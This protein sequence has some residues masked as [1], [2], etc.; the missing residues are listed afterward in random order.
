[1]SSKLHI[2]IHGAGGLG[3]VVGGYLAK[4]GHKVTLISRPAHANAINAGGLKIV[5]RLGDMVIKDNLHAVTMPAQV[6]GEIDYYILLTKAKDAPA[7]L[8][9][10]AVLVGQVKTALTM[11]NGVGKESLLVDCFGKDKVIGGSIIEGGTL[12]EPGKVNNHVTAPTTAFFGELTGGRSD[13]ADR[14]AK[15][16][17]EANLT[18]QSVEDIQHVLWEKVVQV[19]G[20]SAWS[21]STLSAIPELDYADGIS[22]REGA[23]HYVTIAKELIDTYKAMGYAPQDFY[24]P[25]SFLKV[26]DESTLEKAVQVCLELGERMKTIRRGIRTSMHEDLVNGKVTEADA[27]F[28]PLIEQAKKNNVAI[29]TFLGAYRVIKTID[30]NRG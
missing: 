20:A 26:L 16:F 30:S 29:P 6:E 1:M 22:V 19:S 21:A 2:C 9:D 4:S 24:A 3:S 23:E 18:A 5:G 7:A 17:T 11:Q 8:V 14:L 27:L 10:A 15:A 25:F 12:L 28:L 13:R